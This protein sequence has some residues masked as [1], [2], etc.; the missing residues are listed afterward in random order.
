MKNPINIP[1]IKEIRETMF[2]NEVYTLVDD[3]VSSFEATFNDFVQHP[4]RNFSFFYKFPNVKD[5]AGI[6][7]VKVVN[8]SIVQAFSHIMMFWD[9]DWVFACRVFPDDSTLVIR[10]EDFKNFLAE[11]LGISSIEVRGQFDC[12]YD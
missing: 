1:S 8:H 7:S 5:V 12:K 10:Q 4:H 11:D 3:I 2:E 9:T 6:S